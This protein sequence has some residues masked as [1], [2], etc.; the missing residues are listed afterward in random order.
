MNMSV[1]KINELW[2]KDKHLYISKIYENIENKAKYLKSRKDLLEGN[3]LEP[4]KIYYNEEK[5]LIIFEN[6][7]HIFSNLR[8]L[9]CKKIPIITN[10]NTKKVLEELENKKVEIVKEV[11]EKKN[12]SNI[13]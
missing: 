6:G 8:D 12:K 2:K 3:I 10:K 5:E 1:K 4:P 9:G 11:K 7:R 13:K